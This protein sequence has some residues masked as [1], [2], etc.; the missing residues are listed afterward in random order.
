MNCDKKPR[1]INIGI[2][3]FYDALIKQNVK[4]TQIEWHPPVKQSKEMM[5]L[6]DKF[7]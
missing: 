5:E 1:V 2:Q 4:A 3:I 7:L 6:L